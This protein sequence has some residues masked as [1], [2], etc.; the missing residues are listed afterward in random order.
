MKF[1]CEPF[2]LIQQYGIGKVAWGQKHGVGSYKT[3]VL[4]FL[5]MVASGWLPQDGSIG[6]LVPRW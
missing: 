5:E 3:V 6:M 1:F 2:L 4:L